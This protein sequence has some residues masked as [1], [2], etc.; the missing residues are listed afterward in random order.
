MH[1][2]DTDIQRAK[3]CPGVSHVDG[4]AILGREE[5]HGPGKDDVTAGSRLETGILCEPM[6]EARLAAP[7]GSEVRCQLPRV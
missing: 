3:L 1:K 6:A 5:E 4:E 2:R 7:V